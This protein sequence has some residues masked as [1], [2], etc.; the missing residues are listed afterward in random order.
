VIKISKERQKYIV[1]TT[2]NYCEVAKTNHEKYTSFRIEKGKI[3]QDCQVCRK[4]G[5]IYA[6]NTKSVNVLYPNKNNL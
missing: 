3:F 1:T 5:R 2:S 6:L 4:K